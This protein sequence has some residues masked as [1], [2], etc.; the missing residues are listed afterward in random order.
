[1]QAGFPELEFARALEHSLEPAPR[2]TS[3]GRFCCQPR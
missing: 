1:M 3:K 2:G